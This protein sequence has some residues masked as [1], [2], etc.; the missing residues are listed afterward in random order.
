MEKEVM[1]IES[2]SLDLV[3]AEFITIK[4]STVRAVD[5]GNIELQQ[6]G[7]LSI[8][9]ERVEVTQGAS[10][11]MKGETLTLNQSIGCIGCRRHNKSELLICSCCFV[12]R[13]NKCQQERRRGH[14]RQ[15]DQCQSQH[16][17]S[18]DR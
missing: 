1:D 17:D 10:V 9:G 16:F 11:L 14:G 6:V 13:R 2:K 4:Q 15:S 18:H 8:D 12:I 3:E 5:G 7:A